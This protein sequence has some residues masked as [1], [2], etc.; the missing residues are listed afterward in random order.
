[1]TDDTKQN[2]RT[3]DQPDEDAVAETS[4]TTVAEPEPASPGGA[5]LPNAGDEDPH[6]NLAAYLLDSLPEDER[7]EFAA[8]F[9]TCAVCQE[10]A[11]E[12]AP[13][14]GSLPELLTFD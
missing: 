10:E 6:A 5:P 13:I 3:V 8:H 1:M 14:V 4:V 7:A 12:L 9:A 11:R 2:D